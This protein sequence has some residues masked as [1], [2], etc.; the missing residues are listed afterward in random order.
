MGVY[1]REIISASVSDFAWLQ[2]AWAGTFKDDAIE[3]QWSGEQCGTMMGMFRWMREGQIRFYELI[4]IEPAG[5]GVMLRLK[6]FN[7]GLVGWEEKEKAVEFALTAWDGKKAVFYE[8]N[9]P[10]T[11]WMVYHRPDDGTL[12]VWFETPETAE[13]TPFRYR[14]AG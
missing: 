2:G 4:L 12:E 11:I 13:P 1:S 14:R 3:E 7:P 6:H 9:V 8:L 10:K 5:D